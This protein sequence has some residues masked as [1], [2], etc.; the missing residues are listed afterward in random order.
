MTKSNPTHLSIL[1]IVL[2]VDL[3]TLLTDLPTVVGNL[4]GTNV[5]VGEEEV[6]DLT[7]NRLL[8]RKGMKSSNLPTW[9]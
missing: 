4:G 8:L 9:N 1:L 7:R 2:L 6:T 5:V 3:G